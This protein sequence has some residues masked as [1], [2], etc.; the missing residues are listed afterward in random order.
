MCADVEYRDVAC[1]PSGV[2]LILKWSGR[3][4]WGDGCCGLCCRLRSVCRWSAW[5]VL[6]ERAV[7]AGASGEGACGF[8]G[9]RFGA[10]RCSG[11]GERTRTRFAAGVTSSGA[12][13]RT[14]SERWRRVGAASGRCPDEVVAA[15]V[16]ADTLTVAPPDEAACWSTRQM[17][18][19]HGVGKDFVAQTWRERGLGR[20]WLADVFK[21]SADPDFEAKLADVIGLYVDPPERAVV[22]SFERKDPDTGPRPHPAVAAD[23][24]GPQ[25]HPHPRLQEKRHHRPVRRPQRRHWARSSLP[26]PQTPHA[27]S[28][29]L[30]FFKWRRPAH[31]A[32]S[33]RMPCWVVLD[34]LS[35]HKSEPVRTW[36]EP[37]PAAS[38]GTA[39]HTHQQKQTTWANL[40]EQ[41]GSRPDPQSPQS[42]K[43]SPQSKLHLK[44]VIEHWAAH[45]NHDASTPQMDQDRRPDH[46]Q[47]QSSPNAP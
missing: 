11:D 5:R 39:L 1:I 26:D 22:F 29:V 16:I 19:R 20:P 38:A 2:G 24:P 37:T 9:R 8:G 35:A 23:A 7:A 36:L 40:V 27:A 33:R 47:S 18:A 34:D 6:G 12:R 3:V 42:H 30:A 17:A 45:W 21:V 10:R 28:D 13:E 43:H 32:P 15:I 46:R 44:D 25:P 14:G 41:A 31:P 4:W